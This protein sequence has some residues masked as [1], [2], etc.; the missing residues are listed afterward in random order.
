MLG[1][2]LEA[3]AISGYEKIYPAY[4]ETALKYRYSPTEGD[5]EMIDVIFQNR[6]LSFSWLYSN[7]MFPRMMDHLLSKDTFTYSSYIAGGMKK[8]EAW[9]KRLQDR[10]LALGEN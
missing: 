4:V 9:V 10:M 3:M 2:I 1:Y 5:S 7:D 6:I 8:N